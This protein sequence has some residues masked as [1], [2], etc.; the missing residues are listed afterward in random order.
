LWVYKDV[1]EMIDVPLRSCVR[2]KMH[3]VIGLIYHIY[4][5]LVFYQVLYFLF[6]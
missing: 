4:L 2:N 3:T 1:L 6:S 5:S